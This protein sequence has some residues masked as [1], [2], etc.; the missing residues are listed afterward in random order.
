L[1]PRPSAF[2]VER[3]VD[4]AQQQRRIRALRVVARAERD[5]D[6]GAHLRLVP[7]QQEGRRDGGAD[8]L[9]HVL[10]LLRL[11]QPLE[12]NR[13]FVAPEPGQRVAV[14]RAMADAHR[15][16]PQEF[17]AGRMAE[18]VV[19]ILE[20][21]EVEEQHGDEPVLGGRGGPV[22]LQSGLA[23]Q[24][25][26]GVLQTL[27]EQG[28]V[29]Q[30]GKGVVVRHVADAR[31]HP[32][33][34]GDVLE[35]GDP[36]AAGDR[37]VVDE[38]HA[39]VGQRHLGVGDLLGDADAV[40]PG[41]VLLGRHVGPGSGRVA[42]VDDIAQGHANPELA[43]IQIVDLG[44]LPVEQEQA[45]LPVEH[46]QA[47]PKTVEREVAEFQVTQECEQPDGSRTAIGFA[48]PGR[49]RGGSSRNGQR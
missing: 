11:G 37:L 31:L 28:A 10:G 25:R 44:I 26:Q 48:L 33:S 19:D 16:H 30:S 2:L 29:G 27:G 41:G 45:M 7:V 20:V 40:A 36:A 47:L 38:L 35:G 1:R 3:G 15:H 8:P 13:E 5:A 43:G 23:A 42:Q 9:G 12:Q 4:L 18:R 17:I 21:V 32:A 34:L 6:A 24:A 14:A 39:A 49:R 22:V 46:A